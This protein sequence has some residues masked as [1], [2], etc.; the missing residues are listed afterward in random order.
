MNQQKISIPVIDLFAGPGG[1]SEGFSRHSSFRASEVDFQIRLSIEMDPVARKTLRLRS[2]VRQFP[3]GELPEAYYDYVGCTNP[4]EKKKFLEVLEN[5]P[6]WQ[7]A[8]HEAW[9][10]EL[11]QVNPEIL[12][13]RIQK[14]LDGESRWVL[15]GGPPCQVYSGIGRSR[16]LGPGHEIRGIEDEKE[17]EERQREKQKKFYGDVRH[18]LYRDYLKV[19]AIHQPDIFVMENVRDIL[20]ARLPVENGNGKSEMFV[21]DRI[22]RDLKNPWAALK[23]EGADDGWWRYGAGTSHG[24]KIHSFVVPA[25]IPGEHDRSEYLIKCE[26]FGLP[27]TRHRVILLGVRD[28][29]ASVPSTISEKEDKVSLKSMIGDLPPLRSGRSRG[30]DSPSAWLQAIRDHVTDEML[31]TV[32]DENIR[33]RMRSISKRKKT[34]LTR[35]GPFVRSGHSS[36]RYDEE[37]ARWIIDTRLGGVCQHETKTHMDSDIARYLF[38]SVYGEVKEVSPKL[39]HFPNSLLP[40][41]KNVAEEKSG[42][43]RN[44]DFH[45]RFKVQVA[46]SP[47]STVVSHICKDGHYFIHYDPEQCRSL[48]VREAA[49]LQTFPDNY[50]FEGNKTEQYQQVGNAVPPY[51]ALQLAGVV[52][53]VIKTLNT[54][55]EPDSRRVKPTPV[56]EAS[57]P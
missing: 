38:V 35:G 3:E 47:A 40:M 44:R 20:T 12:H 49:R 37:L 43:R 27:Q 7:H 56:S 39:R 2:F 26:K 55:N 51:L 6:E 48:T 28:D 14:A 57:A 9:E 15:L 36:M 53:G 18:A 16:H 41:H 52:A 23:E 11:G 21:F 33:N 34:N 8:D 5:F 25:F 42:N 29:I 54:V 19:V 46:G 17:R 22:L 45:D 13:K 4:K 31:D 32:D 10:A 30:E 24:Y 50:Y 1:L